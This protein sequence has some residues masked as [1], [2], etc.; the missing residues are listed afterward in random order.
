MALEPIK[1]ELAVELFL[2]EREMELSK[3]TL[4]H[5]K[6]HL[7]FF[8]EWCEKEE[9]ENL[10]HLT[11]R[12]IQ[13]HQIWRRDESDLVPQSLKNHMDTLRMF[14]RWLGTIDGVDP[15]LHYKVKSPKIPNGQKSRDAI[16]EAER[17]NRIVNHLKMYEYASRDHI[18]ISLMWHTMLR[19]GALRA[20]DL[21]DYDADEQ[22][23]QL[24]HR[25]EKGTRL[26]NGNSSQRLIALSDEIATTLDHYIA[27][28]RKEVTD[29]YGRPPLVT[30]IHGRPAVGTISKACY[31]WSRPCKVG[32]GCPHGRNPDECV[33]VV[34]ASKRSKCPSSEASHAFRRGGITHYLSKDVPQD[35]VSERADVSGEVLETH[36]DSRTQKDK[37]EQR[38]QYLD[39]F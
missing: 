3:I 38:R 8:L 19:R 4:R 18:I 22:F 5:D 2:N 13:Q 17:A 28:Q 39:R 7:N 10:N 30:T 12:L 29:D 27:S 1:P 9:I 34:D 24:I 35:A 31:K 36:Y 32:E 25:P 26:K 16:I 21:G 37:M 33:A 20:L 14:I 15:D 6:M 23:L 11:G